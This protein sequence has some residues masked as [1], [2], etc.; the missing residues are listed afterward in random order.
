ML[1]PLY[2]A[3]LSGLIVIPSVPIYLLMLYSHFKYRKVFPFQSTFFKLSFSL[4]IFDLMHL[5][6]DWVIGLLHYIGMYD[7]IMANDA[8]FA[9]QFSLLWWYS[10]WG[11]KFGVLCLA[12]DRLACMVFRHVSASRIQRSEEEGEGATGLESEL[13]LE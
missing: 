8:I 2:F 4:G 5:F 7:V 13:R 3:I 10:A 12:I 9:K 11:Q 6:N 1:I